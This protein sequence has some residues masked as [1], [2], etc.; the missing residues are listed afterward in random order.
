[1]TRTNEMNLLP[2]MER[3]GMLPPAGG[4]V[5]V[6]VSGGRDSVCLLHYLA[7]L[8]TARGFSVAAAH[9][10]RDA[11][12]RAELFEHEF[13]ARELDEVLFQVRQTLAGDV[14]DHA[15]VAHVDDHV[16]LRRANGGFG[17]GHTSR[18]GRRGVEPP[19]AGL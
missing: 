13:A 8:G 6:A 17:H 9:L 10:E 15:D 14:E 16:A 12:E 18:Q 4:T 11:V 19:A 5:L 3:W 2:W 1:M 7:R